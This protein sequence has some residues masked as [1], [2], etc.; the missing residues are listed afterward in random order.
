MK[1][2]FLFLFG[3]LFYMEFLF[4]LVC[5]KEISFSWLCATLLFLVPL[6]VFFTY[7][8]GLFKN[9]KIN[10]IVF[11]IITCIALILYIS[12]MIYYKIYD[13]FFSYNSFVFLG[14]VKDG[15]SK[16]LE[17]IL[18]NFIAF[19]F[20][21]LP[22]IFLFSKW[23]RNIEKNNLKDCTIF[24]IFA[25]LFQIYG[26]FLVNSLEKDEKYSMY[27]LYYNLDIP[28]YN[29]KKFGMLTF[30]RLSV[31]RGI[32]S[33]EEKETSSE[34]LYYN[35]PTALL[36]KA[37]KKSNSLDID[38]LSLKEK[39][40]NQTIKQIH[41]YMSTV[42]A[43]L[44]NEST[45]IF[46]NKN[47][48]FMLAESLSTIAID[49]DLTP[50]LYKMYND[51]YSFVNYYSPKYPAGTADGEYMLEWG[52]LPVTGNDYSLIDLVYI[53]H[54]YQVATMFKNNGYKTHA[55]HNYYGYY[56][57][58]DKYFKTL[59]YD[60]YK[61]K[62]ELGISCTKNY[63]AS[64]VDLIQASF[65]DYKSDE[66]FF[67][68][69]ITLSGHGDYS[70][71]GNP[72]VRKNWDKVKDLKVSDNLK[73]YYAANIEYDKALEELINKL[74][75]EGKLDDTVFVIS[76]D[77]SPYFLSKED[78]KTGYKQSINK[79]NQ[80]K[81]TFFIYSSK[82]KPKKI[83]KYGMNIDVLPTL[84][85][86]MGFNY[87]SRLLMGNDLMSDADGLVIFPDR[88]FVTEKGTYN[89][90]TNK[91]NKTTKETVTENY[92]SKVNDKIADKFRYSKLIQYNDYYKYV[93]LG[94]KK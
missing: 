59:N 10:T 3:F 15:F 11:R 68:Y 60:S 7:V 36:K 80:N 29:T 26:I 93:P 87:D 19:F 38:F 75:K 6:C 44:Q 33:F 41:E 28:V 53:D 46:E 13:S 83:E 30:L 34:E 55:Y 70:K 56:N 72:M 8:C 32:F 40:K 27:N 73:G 81:G 52:L 31:E 79:F 20:L 62:D 88:S 91:F 64:D 57:L 12:Q 50:T 21:L 9:K 90:S 84:Y 63:H 54:P 47:V 14:A 24:A 23:T 35:E 51:G 48:I 78:L 58:R 5:F 17:T 39:E 18:H 1:K 66:K 4:H 94:G 86:L 61:F 16:V 37:N 42:P 74:K 22:L 69:Y 76:S 77:H 49:K 82:I 71:S 2:T 85:N 89:S 43:S 45:G 92:V 25:M 65:D 67:T